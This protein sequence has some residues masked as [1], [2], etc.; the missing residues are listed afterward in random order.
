MDFNL[1][2]NSSLTAPTHTNDLNYRGAVEADRPALFNIF[3]RNHDLCRFAPAK[4]SV[5][6]IHLME[7][8]FNVREKQNAQHFPAMQ[9][10]VATADNRIVGYFSFEA[11]EKDVF[12]IDIAVHPD[13]QRNGYA[14]Q[15]LNRLK[16]HAKTQRLPLTLQVSYNNSAAVKLYDKAGFVRYGLNSDNQ[17]FSMKWDFQTS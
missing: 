4:D 10:V 16:V 17:H 2:T 12:V 6:L 13:F 9:T 7:T 1:L 8:Q 11:R 5:P 15:F 14:T 3:V